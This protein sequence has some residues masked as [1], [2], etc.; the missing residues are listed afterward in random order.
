[1]PIKGGRKQIIHFITWCLVLII[2]EIYK[3]IIRVSSSLT[4]SNRFLFEKLYIIEEKLKKL[5]ILKKKYYFITLGF[6]RQLHLQNSLL[7][8]SL[9]I[10]LK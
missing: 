8:N 1:M 10:Y 2:A 4:I 9:F 7:K 3:N 6:E 5:L